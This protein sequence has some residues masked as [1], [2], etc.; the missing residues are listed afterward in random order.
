MKYRGRN[1]QLASTIYK[2]CKAR[3]QKGSPGS[4]GEGRNKQMTETD[5]RVEA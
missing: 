4:K 3:M 2:K 1:R 5:E